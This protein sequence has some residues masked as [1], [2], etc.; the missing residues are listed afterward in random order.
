MQP[1][2]TELS[3]MVTVKGGI[4]S[5]VLVEMLDIEGLRNFQFQEHI[6]QMDDKSFKMTP[7][8]FNTDDVE[9][10]KNDD[11]FV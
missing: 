8:D 7:P 11:D 9:T 10:R 5:S 2:K 4:N 6:L 3:R 1:S